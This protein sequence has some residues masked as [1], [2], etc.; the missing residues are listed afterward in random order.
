MVVFTVVVL[1]PQD[2]NHTRD[3]M[4]NRTKITC[5]LRYE[6]K[7]EKTEEKTQGSIRAHNQNGGMAVF[8]VQSSCGYIA[9]ITSPFL[10]L[11]I[12]LYFFCLLKFQSKRGLDNSA[13]SG[14]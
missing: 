9:T 1:C 11:F 10:Y 2:P 13:R 12:L 7:Q 8:I 5:I 4:R 3:S 6:E 14:R